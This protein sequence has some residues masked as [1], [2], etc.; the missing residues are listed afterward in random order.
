MTRDNIP[1][2]QNTTKALMHDAF[3]LH[4]MDWLTS[5]I[6]VTNMEQKVSMIPIDGTKRYLY[7]Y[8]ATEKKEIA[9]IKFLHLTLN[10]Y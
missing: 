5:H 3:I 8:T 1:A 2:P 6:V 10:I 9:S 7:Q 4:E